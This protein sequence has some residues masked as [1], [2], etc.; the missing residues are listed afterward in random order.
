MLIRFVVTN[1][2]SFCEPT[3][4]NMLTGNVRKKPEHVYEHEGIEFTRAAALY[5]A[6][7]AGKSNLVKAVAFLRD[8]VKGKVPSNQPFKLKATNAQEPSVFEIEFVQKGTLYYYELALL[9][10]TIVKEALY[11]VHPKKEEDHLLF[12][13]T[14]E[15]GK[16]IL[17]VGEEYQQN[18]KEQLL[19]ELYA[20]KLLKK[21]EVFLHKVVEDEMEFDKIV[22]AWEWFY[23]ELA[24][25]YPST[26]HNIGAI[27]GGAIGEDFSSPIRTA[28][29]K[30]DTGI[31]GISFSSI[32]L[33][34]YFGEDDKEMSNT[35][36]RVLKN[37]EG[38]AV[39]SKDERDIVYSKEEEEILVRKLI[40]KHSA[41]GFDDEYVDFSLEEESDGTQRILDL[42]TGT[43]SAL[44]KGK[45][46][47]IDEIDRSIHPSLTK[48][49][50]KSFMDAPKANG[51]LIFT[52][53][54]ANLLDLNIFRQ[55][56]IWFAEKNK[57]GATALYPLSDF[58][59]RADVS[60]K[61][62]YLNG[63]FGA[64]PFLG[65]FEALNW[66]EEVE[67]G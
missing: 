44:L 34:E 15:N 36:R 21:E 5:G 37:S 12:E 24:I 32:P 8:L 13:R 17:L 61:K 53:H 7:G 67:H 58:K 4:F 28:M 64:I 65:D 60:I 41:Q 33:E 38:D 56:E 40:F 23:Q 1:F 10:R 9:E 45:V 55:D 57:E 35:I 30:L 16:T 26:T 25:I 29:E 54:E 42:L 47:L 48:A 6:N 51:Q 46:V 59:V 2:L 11:E 62:G 19:V 27:M 18:P 49:V 52:T 63:R 43:Q 50:V 66:G 31:K 3:E 14:I 22:D 20:E 39:F